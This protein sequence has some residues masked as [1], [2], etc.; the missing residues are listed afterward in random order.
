MNISGQPGRSAGITGLLICNCI[1]IHDIDLT[2]SGQVGPE[3]SLGSKS[4]IYMALLNKT[5]NP[6]FGVHK[7]L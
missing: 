4:L 6:F 1:E 3:D 2:V 5:G 7:S